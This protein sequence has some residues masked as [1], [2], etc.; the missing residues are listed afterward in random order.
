MRCIA[1]RVLIMQILTALRALHKF[2]LDS[3]QNNFFFTQQ[4]LHTEARLCSLVPVS[5][6]THCFDRKAALMCIMRFSW[7][8]VALRT[9]YFTTYIFYCIFKREVILRRFIASCIY[10]VE[11]SIETLFPSL[12]KSYSWIFAWKFFS[13][14]HER[15]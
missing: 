2:I 5:F 9:F 3:Y 14:L 15:H 11:H 8:A 10:I 1:F 12:K 4:V 13:F 7:L 6:V